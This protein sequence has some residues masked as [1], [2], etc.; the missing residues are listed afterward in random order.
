M[1]FKFEIIFLSHAN[2][3]VVWT[4]KKG[5]RNVDTKI[6]R[7]SLKFNLN[8]RKVANTSGMSP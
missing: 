1:E 7:N 3:P 5:T 4:Q 2:M 8:K 6:Q